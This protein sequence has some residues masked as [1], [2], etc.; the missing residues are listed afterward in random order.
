MRDASTTPAK[1]AQ[2]IAHVNGNVPHRKS[3]RIYDDDDEEDTDGNRPCI[4]FATLRR[5]AMDRPARAPPNPARQMRVM[6]RD[7]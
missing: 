4:D 6:D 2:P 3:S 7:N 5:R 1:D